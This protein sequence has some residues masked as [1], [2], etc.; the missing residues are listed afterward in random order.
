MFKTERISLDSSL[1]TQRISW[2]VNCIGRTTGVFETKLLDEHFVQF[3]KN[4]T[5]AIRHSTN[6]TDLEEALN[7]HCVGVSA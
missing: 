1:E 2:L 5:V 6:S 3:S 7:H 4:C